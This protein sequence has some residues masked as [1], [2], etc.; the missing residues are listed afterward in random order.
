MIEHDIKS[1]CL[2]S[3]RE[4]G[5][6]APIRKYIKTFG[7][8]DP[9]SESLAPRRAGPLAKLRMFLEHGNISKFRA[10]AVFCER[11]P[12]R[13]Q[14]DALQKLPSGNFLTHSC[15]RNWSN[16]AVLV[17][18]QY[19]LDVICRRVEEYPDPRLVNGHQDIE[20]ALNRRWWRQRRDR[21]G[22]AAEGVYTHQRIDR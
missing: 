4:P 8:R 3:R 22:H 20:R 15:Y 13:A 14:K 18:R 10:A 16:Q 6:G 1:F 21:L 17:E 7:L 12:E 9:V 19:F 11:D 2:R 5:Q